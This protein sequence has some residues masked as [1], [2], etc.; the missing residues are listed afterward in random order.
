MDTIFKS[1]W[2]WSL[3]VFVIATIIIVILTATGK[4]TNFKFKVG[5]NE[6]SAGGKNKKDC[7]NYDGVMDLTLAIIDE[8]ARLGQEIDTVKQGTLDDQMSFARKRLTS[9]CNDMCE[10]YRKKDDGNADK[11]GL[12]MFNLMFSKDYNSVIVD[13]TFDIIRK[14]HLA[15]KT[16]ESLKEYLR[17][18]AVSQISDL[19]KKCMNYYSPINVK[20]VEQ[21][22]DDNKDIMFRGIEASIENARY[23]SVLKNKRIENLNEHS[24]EIK[25]GIIK[26]HFPDMKDEDIKSKLSSRL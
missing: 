17:I 26:A 25:R 22:F 5:N 12:L 9:L 23:E 21:I 2:F 15:E 11:M 20:I 19:K 10:A 1:S 16:E 4:I 3:F 14:N 24:M 7:C 8:D 13:N 6:F 18:S